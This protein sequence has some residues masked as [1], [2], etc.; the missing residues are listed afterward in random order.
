VVVHKVADMDE[1][2]TFTAVKDTHAK[3]EVIGTLEWDMAVA[4]HS[5]IAFVE[6]ECLLSNLS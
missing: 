5:D 4:D 3:I 6:R 2:F 1:Y